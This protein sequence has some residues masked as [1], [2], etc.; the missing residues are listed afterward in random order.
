MKNCWFFVKCYSF[1]IKSCRLDL[2]Y[3]NH[4]A[5]FAALA[6]KRSKYQRQK[7]LA[8]LELENRYA[9][10]FPSPFTPQ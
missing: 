6:A 9:K 10:G 2:G 7:S 5:S 8:L 3:V 4:V 1:G